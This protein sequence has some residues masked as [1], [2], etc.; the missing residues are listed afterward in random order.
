V[1]WSISPRTTSIRLSSTRFTMARKKETRCVGTV[2]CWMFRDD[3]PPA[4]P[5]AILPKCVECK[6]H[7]VEAKSSPLRVPG[8]VTKATNMAA[9]RTDIKLGSSVSSPN[10]RTT[11]FAQ[12]PHWRKSLRFTLDGLHFIGSEL[13]ESRRIDRQIGEGQEGRWSWNSRF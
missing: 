11:V 7:S 3:Q 6:H 10:T 13:M 12:K 1:M 9:V 8:A 2:W 4:A 5:R